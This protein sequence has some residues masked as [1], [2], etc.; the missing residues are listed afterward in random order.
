M[1]ESK[2]HFFK[3]LKMDALDFLFDEFSAPVDQP[4]A[5]DWAEYHEWLDANDDYE[6][7][8]LPDEA[9]EVFGFED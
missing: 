9:V 7:L 1:R 8:P 4:T 5:E 6:E 3:D 2:Q